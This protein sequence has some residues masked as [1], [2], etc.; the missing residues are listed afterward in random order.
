LLIYILASGAW[1]DIANPDAAK[2]CI[3]LLSSNFYHICT[4][5]KNYN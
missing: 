3:A 5:R 4:F 1:E 2:V